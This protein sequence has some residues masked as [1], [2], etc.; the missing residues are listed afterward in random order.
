[1]PDPFDIHADPNDYVYSDPYQNIFGVDWM[2]AQQN[3]NLYNPSIN[4]PRTPT[5]TITQGGATIQPDKLSQSL[6]AI[7]SGLA[8]LKGRDSIPTTISRDQTPV[9]YQQPYG[10][11]NQLAGDGS[12]GSQ[13]QSFI[14]NNSGFLLIGGLIFA[15][16]MM[17]PP[18][19]RR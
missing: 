18:T 13:I 6:N 2:H 8:I 11:G 15:A 10:A 7:L 9:I 4:Q 12:T 1:M 17:K 14:Q 19:R 3:P 16:F 5:Y